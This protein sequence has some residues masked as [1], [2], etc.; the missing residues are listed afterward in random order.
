MRHAIPTIMLLEM[1]I[2]GC[3]SRPQTLRRRP[4]AGGTMLRA[5]PPLK[6]VQSPESVD[7]A[8]AAPAQE[9]KPTV[10]RVKTT[11]P[12]PVKV[13]KPIVHTVT[14]KDTLWSLARKHL[15]NPKRWSEIVAANPGLDPHKLKIGQKIK[16]PP[17]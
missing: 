10:P 13:K 14:K 12:P 11:P 7:T 17:K 5:A 16:I 8:K 15:G 3:Q 6:R 2:V 1:L 4:T 9:S